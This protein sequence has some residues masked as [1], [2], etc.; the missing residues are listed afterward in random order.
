MAYGFIFLGITI[1]LLILIIIWQRLKGQKT[2]EILLNNQDY[3][4][5]II[6]NT[7]ACVMVI[8]KTGRLISINN[9]G[10]KVL[11]VESLDEVI[12][13][14]VLGI[15]TE[16]YRQQFKD[17]TIGVCRDGKS[18][19][20]IFEIIGLKGNKK[21]LETK[22]VP[23]KYKNG[24]TVILALSEDITEKMRVEL[25]LSKS[26]ILKN[27][28]LSSITDAFF[29][30]DEN[31]KLT[32]LNKQ[33]EELFNK[34]KAELIGKNFWD[35]YP[36]MNISHFYKK[37][38]KALEEHKQIEF[39]YYYP[40]SKKWLRVKIYPSDSGFSIF[41]SDITTEKIEQIFNDLERSILIENSKGKK[42]LNEVFDY[43]I[44]VI[45]SVYPGVYCSIYKID[46]TN[47]KLIMYSA[48]TLPIK[49]K[50]ISLDEKLPCSD[51]ILTENRIVLQDIQSQ[52]KY[53]LYN[54]LLINSSIVSSVSIPLFT[55]DKEP[56][57]VFTI[58]FENNISNN[59]NTIK[60]LNKI[61]EIFRGILENR[62]YEDE[63][64]RLSLI[65]KN[66]SKA[67][68]I[69]NL[70]QEIT[71]VNHAFTE[72]TGYELEEVIGKHPFDLLNGNETEQKNITSLK[73]HLK[74]NELI[75]TNSLLYKKN[76]TTYWSRITGQ[77]MY[78]E[79]GVVNQYFVIQEDVTIRKLAKFE[80]Q[81]SE[82][83]YRALFHSNPQPMFIYDKA[84]LKFK[85]VNESA[86][87]TYGFSSDEF[88]SMSILDLFEELDK[89]MFLNNDEKVNDRNNLLLKSEIK[90]EEYLHH[91]KDGRI[92]N[93]EMVRNK[94][95]LSGKETILVI[96]DDVTNKRIIEKE[97]RRSNERF[98]IASKAVSD[99]IWEWDVRENKYIWG[100]G[101][102]E[103]F[104][105]KNEEEFPTAENFNEFIHPDD[106]EIF[107]KNYISLIKNKS[108]N[109]WSAEYR[110]KK[111]DGTYANVID[112][113]FVIR[114]KKGIAV[115][116]IGAIRDITE[117]KNHEIEKTT[118]IEQTQEFERKRFSMELHDGL[119]QQ[120]IVLNLYLSQIDEDEPVN[121]E[122]L[123]NCFDVVKASLNQTR[124]MC[125]NL[126]PP[127]LENGL[128]LALQ[129][130]FDR[131]KTLNAMDF[132]FEFPEWL[133]NK[134][135]ENVDVYNLYR[136][137]QEF[138]NNSIK[139]AQGSKIECIISKS[140]LT[141][142]IN[143]KDNGIGFDHALITNGLGLNNIEKRAKLAN[144]SCELR[145]EI[146]EGTHLKITL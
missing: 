7:P 94:I 47:K 146:N 122:L 130:M 81:D 63:L 71:W 99:I 126:T 110:F 26:E 45:E 116:V 44:R 74:N 27:T 135:F 88:N 133:S 98:L 77:P 125:Y 101:I 92:L 11:E 54:R 131:F 48:P 107:F 10:L 104:G 78:D 68:F 119:A 70:N 117:Q 112:K 13:H 33:A 139:H 76:G 144:V 16:K 120:L 30:L 86:I 80:L 1:L 100:E 85:E 25:E 35:E 140:D 61:Q 114:T 115:K 106:T 87:N 5:T 64:K 72:M 89:Q 96:I 53:E 60:S 129:A 42:R 3:L 134:D 29:A 79:I 90:N 127:E 56:L 41:N 121:P 118:L 51:A 15:I 31:W 21:W 32:Y 132:I 142:E 23:L 20:L 138:V 91:T 14:N 73:N 17:L 145:S 137:I 103:G 59:T 49:V 39:E 43:A 113:A 24:K 66:T 82:K 62:K 143:L 46:E 8:D 123:K 6:T 18:I 105:Y 57:G 69:S 55:F 50:E 38:L 108:E 4:N 93:I 95:V 67:V 128:L 65:A 102:K 52:N 36:E 28:I 97:L 40:E 124:S 141:L 37:Y 109:Y 111:K 136:I 12:G 22:A 34:N 58:Y 84:T 83:R 19:N 2:K 9:I 75:S